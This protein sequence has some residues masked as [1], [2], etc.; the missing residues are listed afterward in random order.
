MNWIKVFSGKTQSLLGLGTIEGRAS[1]NV[2]IY[3]VNLILLLHLSALVLSSV[4]YLFKAD[5]DLEFIVRTIL[6]AG[7]GFAGLFFNKQRK[8]D[9]ATGISTIGLAISFF[10][11][12]QYYQIT[13]SRAELIF[14]PLAVTAPLAFQ[15]IWLKI[16]GFS[17]IIMLFGAVIWTTD[18]NENFNLLSNIFFVAFGMVM[19]TRFIIRYLDGASTELKENNI[20]LEEQNKYQKEL[21]DQNKLRTELLGILSH[22]LKGPASSFNTLSKKVALLLKGGRYS[23]LDELGEYFARAGDRVY[24][25]I[26]RL[27]NWTIAQKDNIIVRDMESNLYILIKKIEQSVHFEL[28]GKVLDFSKI[29]SDILITTDFHILEIILKNLILNAIKHSPADTV[30]TIS[31]ENTVDEVKVAIHN[32]GEPIDLVLIEQAKLG[33]YRKSKT[34]HGLGLG[35]CFS[36]IQFLDG[37]LQYDISSG[38]TAIVTL[39]NKQLIA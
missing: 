20:K 6:N 17:F 22:D 5:F 38:T 34:G 3:I 4:F 10:L 11:F 21:I 25:D 19:T 29:S 26:D 28:N 36:L 12:I 27:L 16:F 8:Y 23:E 9:L 13:N 14:L 35:I 15:R 31:Q 2:T 1:Q 18:D 39:P 24:H 33:K 30:I 37:Q 32:D 7:L